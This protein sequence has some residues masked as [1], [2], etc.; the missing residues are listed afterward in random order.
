MET[1]FVSKLVKLIAGTLFSCSRKGDV[2][3]EGQS[4]N[5]ITYVADCVVWV[6]AY[7]IIL[8]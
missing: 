4:H 6:N 7:N 5:S 8:Y 1:G 2:V 3:R